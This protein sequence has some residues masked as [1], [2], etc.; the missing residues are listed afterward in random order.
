M[1]VEGD[2]AGVGVLPDDD[3]PARIRELTKRVLYEYGVASM[4]SMS[5]CLPGFLPVANEAQLWAEIGGVGHH[6]VPQLPS[7]IR[8]LKVGSF[9]SRVHGSIRSKVAPSSPMTKTFLPIV[10]LRAR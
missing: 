4:K 1:G 7:F 10:M 9:P 3:V 6:S 5:P 8:R 2:V